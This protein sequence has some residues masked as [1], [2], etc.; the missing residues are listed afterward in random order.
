MTSAS[1]DAIPVVDL[2]GSPH[3]LPHHLVATCHDVGFAV[4]ANHGVDP[5]VIDDVFAFMERFFALPDEHKARID[6]RRSPQLRGWESVGSEFTNNRVDVREQID[7]WSE[8]PLA[9]ESRKPA[10]NR[11]LGPNQWMPDEILPAHRDVTLRW[12]DALGALAERVL[13]LLA[14]GLGL[15]ATHFSDRFG[16]QPM[17]LTKMIHYPPTPTGGAGVNAHHDTGFV[18]LLAPGPTAGLQV[19]NPLGEW[20]DVPSIPDT[21]VVNLGEML[22]AMTGNYLAATAHRV[23]AEH[24]RLS[25]AFFHG[26]SLDTALTPIDLAPSFRAAVEA[27]ERH[28]DA[29]FMATAAEADL[30]AADMSAELRATTYG[31]QLWNYFTRSY[32]D[33]MAAHHSDLVTS[34]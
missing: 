11:L 30:A 1:F 15:D 5:V 17:S 2:A 29:G 32:P 26:P 7:V 33:N 10:W 34:D 6:K 18:T 27:S 23:I 14:I 19:R 31:E 24:E 20:I 16:P 28:R 3:E 8:W 9:T 13:S 22:Q 25:A 4:L 21:L 12:M